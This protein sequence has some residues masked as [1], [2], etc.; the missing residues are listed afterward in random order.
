MDAT[1]ELQ[2][3][4]KRHPDDPAAPEARDWLKKLTH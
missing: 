4:L 1:A 3:F 2:D